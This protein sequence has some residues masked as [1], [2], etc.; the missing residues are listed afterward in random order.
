M[1]LKFNYEQE[2]YEGKWQDKSLPL[3]ARQEELEAVMKCRG[4]AIFK[5]IIEDAKKAK[6]KS[7]TKHGQMLLKGLIE[8]MSGEIR[9]FVEDNVP[10]PRRKSELSAKIL[11]R[12]DYEIVALITGKYVVNCVSLEQILS[13]ASIRIGEALEMECRLEEFSG[14]E[15]R[16]FRRLNIVLLEKR[17]YRR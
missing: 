6:S 3:W 1:E 16:Y 11:A 13:K 15:T 9:K 8:P 12:L 7:M 5:S 17:N 10:A 2:K 14:Q 4:S